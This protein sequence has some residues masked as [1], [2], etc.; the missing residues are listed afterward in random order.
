MKVFTLAVSLLMLSLTGLAQT[1]T[2]GSL[3]GSYT[4]QGASVEYDTWSSSA[5]CTY[6]G[7][8]MTYSGGGQ[9]ASTQ[10]TAGV[11]T[12]GGTGTLTA[13]VTQ[14]GTFDQA[15][16][17]ATVVITFNSE[18]I[19]TIQNGYAV[20]DPATTAV[21]TGDYKVESNGAGVMTLKGQ[22]GSASLQLA[23]MTPTT[24]ISNT[25]FIIFNSS[26]TPNEVSGSAVAVRQQILSE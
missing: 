6:Q 20:F 25:V 22:K 1:Y 18:C 13:N 21:Y 2:D 15:K 16:S 3:S 8:T 4:L 19:P 14:S 26:N 10:A 7:N 9:T 23:A 17:N 5:S 11:I 24:N 12:F